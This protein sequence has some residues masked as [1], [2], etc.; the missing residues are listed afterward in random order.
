MR[1]TPTPKE[2][3]SKIVQIFGLFFVT[4]IDNGT[5]C[6]SYFLLWNL[7][8]NNLPMTCLVTSYIMDEIHIT[9]N[10]EVAFCGSKTNAQSD[11]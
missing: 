8:Y 4:I 1:T 2:S 5:Y 7:L 10:I 3:G 9:Q 11:G 6:R